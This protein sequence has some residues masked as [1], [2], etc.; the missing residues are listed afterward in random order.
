M[1]SIFT[2]LFMF[3]ICALPVPSATAAESAICGDVNNNGSLA[4]SDA[5]AV[6]KAAVGQP[7]TL[8]CPAP[9]SPAKT[10]QT[11]CYN[12]DGDVESCTLTGQDGELRSGIARSF[13]ENNGTIADNVTGLMWE[14]LVDDDL[15]HDKDD[16]Y[17]W[18]NTFLTKIGKL[19][20]L[21]LGGFDDWRVPSRNELATLVNAGAHG[22][23]TFSVFHHNCSPGCSAATCSC[24]ASQAYWSSTSD[25]STP[26]DAWVVSF[27]NGS[28]VTETKT[29]LGPGIRGVR[30]GTN[31]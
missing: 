26:A 9:A 5:L 22:P 1:R 8:I 24:T 21:K 15:F 4:A 30:T 31:K 2:V 20:A 16:N 7:V 19:N 27:D 29:T 25:D 18:S 3:S 11:T 17:T 23:A 12:D 13:T 6:L 14:K 28:V 10:G